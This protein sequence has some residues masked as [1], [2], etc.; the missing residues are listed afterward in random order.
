MEKARQ[1]LLEQRAAGHFGNPDIDGFLHKRYERDK[2]LRDAFIAY[3]GKPIRVSPVY[4]MLGKHSQWESA[5][6]KP[7]VIK[8]PLEKFDRLTVSFTYG[9]SFAIFNPA[10]FGDEEYWNRLYFAD[11]ILNVINRHGYP[12]HVEYDFKRGIYPTDKPINHHLKY[13]EAHVWSNEVLDHYR[14]IWLEENML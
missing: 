13:V 3:G 2:M 5:Y 8:I 9:D 12:P 6:K 11:E 10:L 1:I 7:A 4:M 14:N